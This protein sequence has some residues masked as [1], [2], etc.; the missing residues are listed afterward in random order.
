M[1]GSGLRPALRMAVRDARRSP[2][3]SA[4]TVALLG[5]PVLAVTIGAV[6]LA[7]LDPTPAEQAVRTMGAADAVIVWDYDEPIV[8]DPVKMMTAWPQSTNTAGQIEHDA[9]QILAALPPG[10]RLVEMTRGTVV[11]DGPNGPGR[12]TLTGLDLRD[13][14]TDGMITV[15]DGRVPDEDEVALSQ[16]AAEEL[17]LSTGDS[18]TIAGAT[19]R[20]SGVVEKPGALDEHF[21]VAAPSVLPGEHDRWL[22]DTVAPIDWDQVRRYN[23]IGMAVYSA[24]VADDPPPPPDALRLNTTDAPEELVLVTFGIVMVGLEIVLLAGPA[25]AISAKRR[26]REFALLAANGAT[27]G[28]VRHTLLASGLVLGTIAAVA[29][30]VI[31]GLTA[32]AAAPLAEQLAGQRLAGFRIWPAITLPAAGLTIVTGLLAAVVPAFTVARQPLATTLGGRRGTVRSRARWMLLGIVMTVAGGGAA[33]MAVEQSLVPPMLAGV[34]VGELGLVLCTPA[35]IGFIAR[36][37]RFLPLSARMAL[38][39]AGRNRSATAPAISAIM[40]VVACGIAVT[41]FT[42]SDSHRFAAG[43]HTTAPPGSVSANVS[44]STPGTD[45]TVLTNAVDEIGA[46]MERLLPVTTIHPVSPVRC[47]DGDPEFGWCQP[48][49]VPA[50]GRDCPFDPRQGRLTAEQQA[51]AVAN[52]HCKDRETYLT[53]VF[54][55]GD[56][57]ADG[58]TLAAVTGTDSAE[59]AAAVLAAGGIVVDDPDLVVDGHATV[60]IRQYPTD[61]PDPEVLATA[62]VPAFALGTGDGN[63]RQVFYSP[64]AAELLGLVADPDTVDIFA[65]TDRAPTPAESDRFG[66]ALAAHGLVDVDSSR[67][68]GSVRVFWE[69]AAAPEPPQTKA[70]VLLLLAASSGVLALIVTAVATA[71][72]ATEARRDL[73]TLGEIGASPRMR[74]KLS[75]CRAGVISLLGTV[76]GVAAGIGTCTMALVSLNSQLSTAYPRQNLYSLVPPWLNIAVALVA[77]PVI[78]MVGA[79]LLTRSRLPAERRRD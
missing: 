64:G 39:D 40:A 35:L 15:L 30:L 52:P 43:V 20:I 38:R 54:S 41:M 51:E 4:L 19:L 10:S 29:G 12:L 22:A 23:T 73:A 70:T 28:Q 50:P 65:A 44:L 3:R 37:A 14:I 72:A 57:L 7:S 71:L 18:I 61:G 13:P 49:V 58:P 6:L 5:L 48:V 60:E 32:L 76:L 46:L 11:V 33:A 9:E 63:P 66:R 69:V 53:G 2:R 56:F 8:Q 24:A 74:R 42:V 21:A 67:D 1:T 16:T 62:T 45:P 78:A 79:G 25:F 75:L 31:G 59:A 77:V 47:A 27:P 26:S 68:D 36:G 34:I 55:V 17:A